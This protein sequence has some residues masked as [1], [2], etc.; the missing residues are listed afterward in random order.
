MN[1]LTVGLVC[2]LLF[3]FLLH[4]LALRLNARSASKELPPEF[5]GTYDA[6]E[7]ARSQEYTRAQ[8]RLDTASSTV[9]TFF[10]VGFILLGG[11]A[12]LETAVSALQA[13]W[14]VQGLVFLGSFAAIFELLNLPL[15]LASVFGLEER[16]GFNRTTAAT[17]VL[18]KLKTY[19]LTAVIGAVAASGILLFFRAFPQFGWLL[20]WAFLALFMLLLQYVGPN[21]ILPLFNRFTPL[22]EGPLREAI[23][24]TARK[25]GFDLEGISVMDGSKRSN[26]SNAF[27]TGL[28]RKK[29][30]VLFDTLINRHTP[31]ELSAVLAH[32]IGHFKLKHIWKKTFLGLAQTGIILFLLSL[33]LHYKTL[34]TAFGLNGTPI[35]AGLL[36]FAILY[37]PVN[38]LVSLATNAL[39]RCYEYE[40][41]KFAAKAIQRPRDLSSA[42][43]RLA[44]DNLSNL[45]PHRLYV[46]LEYS[47]PPILERLRHLNGLEPALTEAEK[48]G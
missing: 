44:R 30:I 26:K 4:N 8:S 3:Y 25:T 5:R 36:F 37:S 9:N 10:L 20:A 40:A 19:G 17:F 23:K 1:A 12:W 21:W 48:E 47:H 28:G 18:D 15:E 29:R 39:S 2:F 6:A 11:F 46:C 14:L 45:T 24:D 35:Y 13:P 34:Y 38:L 27:F 32:E 43:K 42:L 22:E 7:Y 31:A 16:Y 33:V 41:D